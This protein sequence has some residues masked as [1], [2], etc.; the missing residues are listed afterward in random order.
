LEPDFP[1]EFIVYGT[2]V[3]LQRDN[4]RAKEEWKAL[5]KAASLPHLPEMHF[6]TDR[7]LA[8]TLF[9]FPEDVMDGDVDNIVKLILDALSR[10]IYLDDKQIERILIQ[11]FESNRAFTFSDPSEILTRC[12]LGPK[13]ALYIRIS[14]NP[15]EDL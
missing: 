8:I 6:A 5:V 13:P 14:V 4:P 2:P 3:S 12:A 10:H 1:I 7:P 9:Y 11:K 15:H